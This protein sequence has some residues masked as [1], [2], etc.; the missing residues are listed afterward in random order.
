MNPPRNA[1]AQFHDAIAQ[2]MMRMHNNNC[3]NAY[4]APKRSRT[5]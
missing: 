4:Q 3:A 1:I 2:F 5:R